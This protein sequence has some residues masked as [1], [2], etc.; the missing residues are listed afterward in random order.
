MKNDN[1]ELDFQL[2]R[3]SSAHSQAGNAL[4][5]PAV[6]GYRNSDKSI[7]KDFSKSDP[8]STRGPCSILT[9]GGRRIRSREALDRFDRGTG[10]ECEYQP[11]ILDETQNNEHL[12][13]IA[14]FIASSKA[15]AKELRFED[16]DLRPLWRA[17]AQPPIT[18]ESL[19]VLDASRL[20]SYA[21]LCRDCN[22]ESDILLQPVPSSQAEVYW[23]VLAIEF[24]LY[25]QHNSSP[26]SCSWL[27][28]LTSN[29]ST[30]P[31]LRL[32]ALFE[33][34]REILKSLL[35][36]EIAWHVD[37]IIE[38]SFLVRQIRTDACDLVRL[39][40]CIHATCKSW[41]P[42]QYH[43]HTRR[44]VDQLQ[45]ATLQKDPCSIANAVRQLLQGLETIKLVHISITLEDFL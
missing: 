26:S 27:L 41:W 20:W 11:S 1:G 39:A 44:F 21:K 15:T 36:K 31:R 18:V 3:C 16:A 7:E 42:A 2:C 35:P 25:I 29:S 13:N 33:A 9:V 24:A 14:A 4:H 40:I 8:S 32:Q 28:R 22:F 19:S 5:D 45:T 17:G 38:P 43:I 37:T 10:P 30:A 34:L 12:F 23:A 6:S